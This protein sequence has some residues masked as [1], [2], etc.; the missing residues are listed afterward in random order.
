[1]GTFQGNWDIYCADF[2]G[3]TIYWLLLCFWMGIGTNWWSCT[4]LSLGYLQVR[5][6]VLNL[7]GLGIAIYGIYCGY[8]MASYI[9]T[10][11][12]WSNPWFFKG[13][14]CLFGLIALRCL[15]REPRHEVH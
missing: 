9:G 15:V 7:V 12:Y 13:H 2:S 6:L 11:E 1:V 14:A 8:H 10:D 4:W 3:S 5:A